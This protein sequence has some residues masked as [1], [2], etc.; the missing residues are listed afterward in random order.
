MKLISIIQN[1]S[2]FFVIIILMS[3]R[4]INIESQNINTSYMFSLRNT[5]PALVPVKLLEL[6]F[7]FFSECDCPDGGYCDTIT[8]NCSCGIA[9]EDCTLCPPGY[10]IEDGKCR[11]CGSCVQNLLKRVD[12]MNINLTMIKENII[13]PELLKNVSLGAVNKTFV[14]Y[15]NGLLMKFVSTKSRSSS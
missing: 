15:C 8:G 13:P 3:I 12:N 5:N 1:S 7:P 9:G 2:I 10:I 6:C 14:R 11:E 4:R